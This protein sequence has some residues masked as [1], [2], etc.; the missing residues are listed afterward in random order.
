VPSPQGTHDR[1]HIT[2]RMEIWFKNQWL[3][4]V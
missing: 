3:K 2:N 4:S 1:R